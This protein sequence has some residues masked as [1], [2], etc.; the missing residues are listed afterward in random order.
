[1]KFSTPFNITLTFQL[2]PGRGGVRAAQRRCLPTRI[3][4]R[5]V[6]LRASP[7]SERYPATPRP[8]KKPQRAFVVQFGWAGET[9]DPPT[10]TESRC[11][12]SPFVQPHVA[13]RTTPLQ[14][15]SAVRESFLDKRLM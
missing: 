4:K 11:N 2:S 5:T 9:A 10:A 13:D 12:D 7:D 6:F 1:M 15:T 8:M 14:K 3:S